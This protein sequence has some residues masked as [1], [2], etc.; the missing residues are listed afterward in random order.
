MTGLALSGGG[1]R[2]IAHI[3]VLK[4]LEE[5]GIVPDIVAGTSAG[6]IIGALF[7]AGKSIEEM[8]D[9]VRQGSLY[10]LYQFRLPTSGLTS[11][12]YLRKILS[13]ALTERTI[14]D[15]PK[16]LFITVSNLTQGEV[17]V[18]TQGE[19][20]PAISASCAIPLVFR[21]IK[22][23]GQTYVDGGLFMN[24]PAQP[25]RFLC[26]QLIGVNVMPIG[27][28]EAKSVESV[29]GIASRCFELGISVNSEQSRSMCDLLIEPEDVSRYNIFQFGKVDE[30]FEIGYEAGKKAILAH[31]F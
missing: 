20:I 30:L 11:L 28:V 25:I 1:A 2:G 21:P 31:E 9:F 13:G 27:E 5:A 15:L 26:D 4:A 8:L 3:G 24:L 29:I 16:Q 18:K 23:E 22:I 12:A 6:A 14:E 19:L 17:E 10:K 7:A